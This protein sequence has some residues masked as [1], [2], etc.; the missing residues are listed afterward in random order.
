M[1]QVDLL[2]LYQHLE[3]AKSGED[4]VRAHQ[5]VKKFLLILRQMV[6]IVS[7][8]S[9]KKVEND[10]VCLICAKTVAAL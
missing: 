4:K 2:V 8:L 10:T 3:E 9:Q 1:A 5:D 7:S 6:Q